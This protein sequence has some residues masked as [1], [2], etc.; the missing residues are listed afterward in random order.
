APSSPRS[1]HGALPILGATGG[2]DFETGFDEM[3]GHVDDVLLV[4]V[5][6]RDEGLARGW[7]LLARTH[8]RLR[9]SHGE[10]GVEADDFA[11]RLHFRSEEHTS[12]LQSREHL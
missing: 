7:H 3:A 12:E 1:L 10:I 11:G 5:T 6:H 4:V 2:E 9:E 8:L